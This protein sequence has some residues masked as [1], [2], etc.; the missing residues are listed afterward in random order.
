MGDRSALGLSRRGV[1]GRGLRRRAAAAAAGSTSNSAVGTAGARLR[2]IHPIM[3]LRW[4]RA[5]VLAMV[6]VTALLYL[7]VSAAADDQIADARRTQRSIADIAGA[8]AAAEGA[9]V[10]LEKAFDTANV[11]LVGTESAQESG[12]LVLDA[13]DVMVHLFLSETRER[14]GLER[15]WRDAVEVSVPKLLQ[16]EAVKK[17][18]KKAKTT[19]SKPKAP[20]KKTK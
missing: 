5:G 9:K 8:R 15:L 17:P 7:V 13:F 6:A 16:I 11:R 10:A 19:G 12:W 3:V 18:A 2:A 20:R 4:L 1:G 14:F